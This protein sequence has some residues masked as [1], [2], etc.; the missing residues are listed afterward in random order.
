VVVLHGDAEVLKRRAVDQLVAQLLGE[1]DL[2][3]ALER[4]WAREVGTD[5]IIGALGSF[6]LLAPERV[7]LIHEL[8][9]LGAKEQ[10]RLAAPLARIAPG[11]T[12]V[13][14]TSPPQERRERKPRLAADL[15][16]VIEKGGEVREVFTPPERDLIPWVM[17][18]AS[19]Y[20]K[21]LSPAAAR[22][23]VEVVGA[24]CDRLASEIAKLASYA[25]ELPEIDEA[26]VREA[27]SPAD[28]RTVFDLVDAIGRKD[29][30][31]ALEMVRA[32]LPRESRR[33]AAIPLLGMIA[34]HLRLLWQAAVVLKGQQSLEATVPAEL[35]AR[36]PAETNLLDA[37]KGKSFL[38][39]KYAQQARNFTEA[40]LARALVKVYEADLSLK[41]RG[42]GPMEDRM[43]IEALVIALCR[44]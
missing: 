18:E 20:G 34:R 37:L 30:P 42:D 39:R 21:Q 5:T 24:S 22:L 19:R 4:L 9:E 32:L 13:I 23:L 8:Q 3:Y 38:S 33:G 27:A 14:T 44:R 10:R 31:T 7:V 2:E 35:R 36:L 11:T 1:A 12:V 15:M 29:L 40:Q 6:S 28:D 17:G 16:K 41:G 25:G 43:V 26:A